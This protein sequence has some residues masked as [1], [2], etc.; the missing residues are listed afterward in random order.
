MKLK[1]L[2]LELSEEVTHIFEIVCYEVGDLLG[3]EVAEELA[4]VDSIL[5]DYI[6]YYSHSNCIELEQI[7]ELEL[8]PEYRDKEQELIMQLLYY[9]YI[10]AYFISQNRDRIIQSYQYLAYN[11][12]WQ[13]YYMIETDKTEVDDNFYDTFFWLGGTQL[14]FGE[15]V[16]LLGFNELKELMFTEKGQKTLE[17]KGKYFYL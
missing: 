6:I 3:E 13:A 7:D 4:C 16:R 12:F 2:L 5:Q 15:R 11:L 17:N 9:I 1:T 8:L 14:L 10:Y